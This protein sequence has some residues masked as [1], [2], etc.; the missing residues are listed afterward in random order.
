M[1]L[2]DANPDGRKLTWEQH[3]RK[4]KMEKEKE[5]EGKGNTEPKRSGRC[6]VCD[7]GG[8]QLSCKGGVI[9]R[10]CKRCGDER[11]FM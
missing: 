1:K 7:N 8:F 3:L 5:E 6:D 2:S 11:H 10:K 4:L 9:T